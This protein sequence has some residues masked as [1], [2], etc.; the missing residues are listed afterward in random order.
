MSEIKL[1][2]LLKG[3]EVAKVED[4]S[5]NE[6]IETSLVKPEDREKVDKIKDLVNVRDTNGILMY[7][8]GAQK[9]IA[10]FSDTILTEI[11]NKDIGEVGDLLGELM[12]E[13]KDFDAHALQKKES[14]LKKIPIIGNAISAAKSYIQRYEVVASQID[15]IT[16]KLETSKM[17]LLKDLSM[18]DRL[19]DENLNYFNELN[20]YILAGEEKVQELKSVTLPA[21]HKEVENSTD[22]M[23]L[24]VVKEFEDDIAQFEKKI[25]DLKTSK[26]IALQTAPTIKLIQNNNKLLISKLQDSINNVIPIWKS[27]VLIALGVSRQAQVLE[28]Q[29]DIS[30]MTNKM[31]EKNAENLKQNTIEI[32]KEAERSTVDVETL[33]K[34][35]NTLIST[36]E[37][38]MQ[39]HDDA[40]KNRKAAEKEIAEIEQSLKSAI[41]KTLKI[42]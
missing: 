23:A 38:T 12:S 9:N 15:K 26:T 7:G 10:Q 19:Y 31:L 18:M 21:L 37:E 16:G 29:K 13:V 27:Q 22:P 42:N 17:E 14:F 33:R 28:M 1:N 25:Y 41:E 20:L 4:V 2:D 32:A 30:D 36:I 11:K 39:I 6:N 24:Q 5:L 8:S 34:V 40:A 3:G 35:N